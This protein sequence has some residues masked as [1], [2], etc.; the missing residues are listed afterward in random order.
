MIDDQEIKCMLAL[1]YALRHQSDEHNKNTNTGKSSEKNKKG[2]AQIQGKQK[3]Q[4]LIALPDAVIRDEI[5]SYRPFRPFRVI[6]I[7]GDNGEITWNNRNDRNSL[8][9]RSSLTKKREYCLTFRS[10]RGPLRFRVIEI[11]YLPP[12]Q[13]DIKAEAETYNAADGVIISCYMSRFFEFCDRYGYH[14][15]SSRILEDVTKRLTKR[16]VS[17]LNDDKTLPR[18][19]RK[20]AKMVTKR[21]DYPMSI[22]LCSNNVDITHVDARLSSIV[23]RESRIGSTA[24]TNASTTEGY[25]KTLNS[26]IENPK[27]PFSSLARSLTSDEGLE[28]IDVT[29]NANGN[30]NTDAAKWEMRMVSR[31]PTKSYVESEAHR[32]LPEKSTWSNDDDLSSWSW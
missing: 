19:N 11:P 17:Y 32:L 1:M 24:T 22:V 26:F 28:F 9:G 29:A 7:R 3:Q 8:G 27:H 20:K 2:K 4:S 18:H 6:L 16:Q 10:N 31:K 30:A 25:V 13:Y 14:Y 23:F 5:L 21:N 15:A 12:K